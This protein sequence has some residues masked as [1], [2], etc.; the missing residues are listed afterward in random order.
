[1]NIE[2]EYDELSVQVNLDFQ[3]LL[4]IRNVFK[5]TTSVSRIR[6][7]MHAT[8]LEITPY[9][10]MKELQKRLGWLDSKVRDTV[11]E[12]AVQ[13]ITD[14]FD[15]TV[16]FC[17]LAVAVL[18]DCVELAAHLI[19]EGADAK[20]W[21]G[22]PGVSL[23]VYTA[24]NPKMFEL[25]LR[26]GASPHVQ[27]PRNNTTVLIAFAKY[28][29]NTSLKRVVDLGVDVNQVCNKTGG[30]VINEAAREGFLS[31]KKLEI[32]MKAGADVFLPL[33]QLQ[34]SNIAPAT[35]QLLHRA[36]YASLI[37]LMITRST[38]KRTRDQ[39]PVAKLPKGLFRMLLNMLNG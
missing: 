29:G 27:D 21:E 38:L 4:L 37:L 23:L 20:F 24:W 19:D 33:R 30:G 3:L 25:L 39:S 16:H 15:G 9:T 8:E 26:A 35:L 1:M 18:S 32:L 7:M 6:Q 10:W 31:S 11:I 12:V 17:P 14:R 28:G 36:A 2:L 13:A 22:T 34:E 5:P